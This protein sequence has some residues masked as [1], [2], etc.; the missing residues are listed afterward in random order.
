MLETR[1]VQVIIPLFLFALLRTSLPGD[2]VRADDIAQDLVDRF[3]E[4]AAA[5]TAGAAAAAGA[6]GGIDAAEGD[7]DATSPRAVFY[8]E[9]DGVEL[10][11]NGYTGELTR[12]IGKDRESVG[13]KKM[14]GEWITALY[15]LPLDAATIIGYEVADQKSGA[16]FI[17]RLDLSPLEIRWTVPLNSVDLKPFYLHRKLIYAC[18]SSAIVTVEPDRG[19]LIW[20][21]R[22]IDLHGIT[23]EGLTG[24][25]DDLIVLGTEGGKFTLLWFDAHTGELLQRISNPSGRSSGSRVRVRDR[26]DLDSS[27]IG[28]LDRGELVTVLERT[29]RRMRIDSMND[30]W[31]RI[32][33]DGGLD[34]WSYGHY[35]EL[36]LS[37][38]RD[39]A[40]LEPED[41]LY[42]VLD[43]LDRIDARLE[44]MEYRE[45]GTRTFRDPRLRLWT[46]G[47]IT[48]KLMAPEGGNG[49]APAGTA[50]YYFSEGNLL[51]AQY[52]YGGYLFDE[53]R[54]ILQVN[55]FMD[56]LQDFVDGAL[57]ERAVEIL[58]RVSRYLEAF[59]S[60]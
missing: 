39:R 37:F 55:E 8:L 15:Y 33:T 53:G 14:R 24:T 16:S 21:A 13:L 38:T 17:S 57:E 9:V 28:H 23:V 30:Y 52:P 47:G 19:T 56:P 35:I 46:E 48:V 11:V 22:A 43:M 3:L 25:G 26:P 45:T 20:K 10:S 1:F 59:G 54:I 36:D 5:A 29:D 49:D 7:R 32:R 4:S 40:R 31:Y 41:R 44:A 58:A 51:F 42:R 18:T 50:S 27:T 12:K 60:R 6:A 2:A 34:G